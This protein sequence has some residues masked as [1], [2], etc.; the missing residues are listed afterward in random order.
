MTSQN[1]RGKKRILSGYV[2]SD[3]NDKTIVVNTERI[4]QHP[5][6]KK[7]VKSRKKFM[8]HDPENVCSTGDKV[9]IIESPRLSKRKRWRLKKVLEK[10]V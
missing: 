10:A 3:K 2:V 8:A 1:M 5:L 7:Y 9:Q 6:Y 4:I